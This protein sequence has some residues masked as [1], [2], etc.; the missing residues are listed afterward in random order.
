MARR[1]EHAPNIQELHEL[2]AEGPSAP[3]GYLPALEDLHLITLCHNSKS[4]M[5]NWG[6]KDYCLP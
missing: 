3:V 2:P 5:G 6:Y 4:L 1:G